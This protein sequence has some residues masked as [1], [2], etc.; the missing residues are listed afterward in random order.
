MRGRR[1]CAAGRRCSQARLH[2]PSN[3]RRWFRKYGEPHVDY[4]PT[5]ED[6]AAGPHW[7]KQKSLR[8]AWNAFRDFVRS[9]PWSDDEQLPYYDVDD[10]PPDE[11]RP[12]LLSLQT[13]A[14]ARVLLICE[15]PVIQD[16]V[17]KWPEPHEP[18]KPSVVHGGKA[19]LAWY[20]PLASAWIARSVRD[21][22]RSID[23]PILFFGDM[24][25]HAL[26]SFA[27][28]RAGGRN[29]LLKGTGRAVPVT[30]MGIDG[31]WLAWASRVKGKPVGLTLSLTW[32]ERE[33]WQ[34]VKR[35]V[36]DVR[37]LIGARGYSMLE[38]G[39]KLEAEPLLRGPF[40][41]EFL[42]RLRSLLPVDDDRVC[43][44]LHG[45]GQAPPE[46]R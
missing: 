45:K 8:G 23:A 31:R 29:A 36:P 28:L 5:A 13:R 15:K 44:I 12:E 42:R 22:A 30:W 32:L 19:A 21:H 25:P 7:R 1:W 9:G 4:E 16:A 27:A 20:A 17:A 37:R 35:L 3:F 41:E 39:A 11:W 24:D 33:Y 46:A 40:A 6:R 14:D 10:E 43:E 26:H 34:F 18:G 38:S 2:A